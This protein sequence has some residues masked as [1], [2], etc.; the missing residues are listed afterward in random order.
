MTILSDHD[1][2]A[3]NA[4]HDDEMPAAERRLFE[5]RLK[6]EP[7]LA[8][9]L[10]GLQSLS[11]RLKT[12][13]PATGAAGRH[14]NTPRLAIIWT[15]LAALVACATL[16]VFWGMGGGAAPSAAAIHAEFVA[17]G[18][19]NAAPIPVADQK[20]S[21]FPELGVAGLIHVA[22]R[23]DAGIKAAH[24]AGPNGC[25]VTLLVSDEALTA[26]QGN[27]LRVSQWVAGDRRFMFLSEGM[28]EARF[29][30]IARYLRDQTTGRRMM[31]T[32]LPGDFLQSRSCA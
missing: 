27:A 16:A 13:R 3:L 31:A 10:R 2:Q 24:Y 8:D 11:G 6:A 29:A 28:D 22:S 12:L 14:R 32:D 21:D 9:E 18:R 7:A 5:R 30:L 26:P 25:R 19:T 17:A 4:Y 23:R 15:G 1:W 20:S